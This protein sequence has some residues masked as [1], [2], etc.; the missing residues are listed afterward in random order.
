MTKRIVARSTGDKFK[1]TFE[2]HLDRVYNNTRIKYHCLT[3]LRYNG[4]NEG[5]FRGI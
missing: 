5:P 4:S 2:V 3:F 1:V